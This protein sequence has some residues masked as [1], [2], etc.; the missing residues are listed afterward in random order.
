MLSRI[1]R[2]GKDGKYYGTYDQSGEKLFT[3]DFPPGSLENY[4][5]IKACEDIV[6]P[7]LYILENSEPSGLWYGVRTSFQIRIH[8]NELSNGETYE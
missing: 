4:M 3:E 1:G 5:E 8:A 7:R 2:D 6:F